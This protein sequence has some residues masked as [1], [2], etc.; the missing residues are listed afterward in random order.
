[1]ECRYCKQEVFVF[2]KPPEFAPEGWAT[3]E[4]GDPVEDF[5]C[6]ARESSGRFPDGKP[7]EVVA[8]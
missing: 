6:P 7:H 8:R 3:D 2:D 4:T 1:M 5:I